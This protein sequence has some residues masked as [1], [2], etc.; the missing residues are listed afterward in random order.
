[1]DKSREYS[2]TLRRQTAIMMELDELIKDIKVRYLIVRRSNRNGR[3]SWS[4]VYG[5]RSSGDP[6]Y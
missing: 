2:A 6:Q 4:G 3:K 1:M 5:T